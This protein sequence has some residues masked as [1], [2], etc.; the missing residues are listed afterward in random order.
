MTQ[1]DFTKEEAIETEKAVDELF[2]AIPKRKRLNY[3]G[4]LNDILLFVA[5]AREAAPDEMK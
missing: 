2:K 5:A 1:G 4:H 3:L